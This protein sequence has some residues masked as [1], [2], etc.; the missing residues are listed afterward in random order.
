MGWR[1][2][3]SVLKRWQDLGAFEVWGGN[4]VQWKL[5]EFV[6]VSLVRNPGYEGFSPSSVTRQVF[7]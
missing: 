1:E 4:V 5:S 6:R 7:K 3:E 2:R